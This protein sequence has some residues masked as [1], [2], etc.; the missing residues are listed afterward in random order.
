MRR[1]A[2]A[3]A[4]LWALSSP[5]GA[6]EFVPLLR[7]D[8]LGGRSTMAGAAS[9]F[10]GNVFWSLTPAVRFSDRDSFIPTIAGQYRRTYEAREVVGGSFLTHQALD[11]M[12]H[13]KWVHAFT[14]SIL[15]KP[16]CAFKN[17]MLS[18]VAGEALGQGLFNHHK[19][20]GGIEFERVG[21]RLRSLRNTIAFYAVRFYNFESLAAQRFGSEIRGGRAVL[22]FNALDYTLALDWLPWEGGLLTG[23]VN[24]SYRVFPDQKVMTAAGIFIDDTRGDL[25]WSG[26]M[27]LQH[28]WRGWSLGKISFEPSA[29]AHSGFSGLISNQNHYDVGRLKFNPR[30]YDYHGFTAGPFVRLKAGRLEASV[31]YDFERREYPRRR[32]QEENG[33]YRDGEAVNTND[34]I[35]SYGVSL[36]LTEYLSLK[37][38]G[39]ERVSSS[40]TRHER[41]YRYNF[42][43]RHYYAGFSFKL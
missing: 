37:V 42:Q 34:H 21:E 33:A 10:G 4:L 5:A 24:G 11:N 26:D 38:Q 7:V 6:A 8:V 30:Y 2:V 19:V 32:A 14:D 31:S 43:S 41:T 9:N 15:A 18:E 16:Y 17:E 23:S 40:S 39:S 12:I 1:P 35:W 28:R 29:G 22:D 25:A 13:L 36:V 27:G 20:S 3:A